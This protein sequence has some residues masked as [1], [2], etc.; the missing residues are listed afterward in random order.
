MSTAA[1]DGFSGSSVNGWLIVDER[2]MTAS[3]AR[4]SSVAYGSAA[5]SCCC[6]LTI[7]D[8]AISS[9]ARV[10]LAMDWTVSIRRLTRRSLA[11]MGYFFSAFWFSAF[12]FSAFFFS[13]FF[14]SAFFFSAF[15]FSAFFFS[16]FWFSAFWFS[17]GWRGTR[18]AIF[19]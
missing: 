13:A 19:S 17:A 5:R 9:C 18:L 2:L 10:I 3:T 12:W 16:A 14:F 6:A 7:R 8:D 1:R 11:P 15:F 4:V